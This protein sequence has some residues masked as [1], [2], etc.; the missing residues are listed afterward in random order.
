MN[1]RTG[2]AR[3]VAALLLLLA[4]V[5][6]R[7]QGELGLGRMWTFHEPPTQWL[8][9]TY[10]F[11]PDPRWFDAVRLATL[12]FGAGC[13]ASFVSS[14]GLILT[15]HHCVS[16]ALARHGGAGDLVRDG[17]VATSYADEL[18]LP[19]LAVEQLVAMC[20]ITERMEAGIAATDDP[21][22]AA[23]KRSANEER[24]L[25]AAAAAA[26]LLRAEVVSLFH[27]AQWQLYQYRVFDDVRLVMAPHLQIAHFGGD[28]DNFV[29]PR[30]SIDF[31]FCRAWEGD[32]PVDTKGTHF[33]WSDGPSEGQLV[34][35]AGNPG[36]T[37]RLLGSKQLEYLRDVRYPRVREQIDHRLAILRAAIDGEPE[38]EQ[39][40]RSALLSYENGQKL[41]RGEHGALQDPAFM[42]SKVAG[43]QKLQARLA[44]DPALALRFGGLFASIAEIAAARRSS[45][46]RL[47]FHSAGGWLPLQRALALVAMAHGGDARPLESVKKSRASDDSDLQRA[48]FVDHLERARAWLPQ[49]DPYLAVVLDGEAPDAV[50]ERLRATLLGDALQFAAVEASGRD[51]I[52]NHEDLLLRLARPLWP[53]VAAA[54]REA[55]DLEVRERAVMAQFGQAVFAVYGHAVSPDASMTLRLSDGLVRG[56]GYNGTIA[57]WRTLMQGLFARSNEFDGRPP[58]DLPAAWTEAM[59]RLDPLTPV[60]FV[61]TCDSTGGNSGS[62][63]IDVQRRLVGL[64]FDGNIESL[65][66]EFLFRDHSERSVCVHPRAILEALK[67]VYAA[68]TLVRELQAPR[69]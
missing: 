8:Q 54:R 46:G 57:P 9:S 28:P 40:L 55:E 31:A 17:F 14:Q 12:R 65:G 47:H 16:S 26:P 27:G 52:Q 56:Y 67:H 45:E 23:K 13:S 19:E 20:D 64:L 18:R 51:A 58:F 63:V 35:L 15:N 39:K 34:F 59:P 68:D 1:A 49:G 43:E 22:T 33:E 44:A 6:L 62:P 61:C 3:G 5:S 11:T 32:A 41:Y 37:Q 38:R 24:V 10:D 2:L 4:S 25:A 66:N 29:Y 50:A 69:R 42:A 53:I 30:H 60:D 36:R 21:A 7:A 48:F